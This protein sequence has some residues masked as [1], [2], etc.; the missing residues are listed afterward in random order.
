MYRGDEP[1]PASWDG[2]D[3]TRIA[4]RIAERVAELIGGGVETVV[5]ADEGVRG[6]EPLADLFARDHFAWTLEKDGEQ[7][8]GLFLQAYLD[9]A[10]TELSVP[11]VR[12]ENSE[13]DDVR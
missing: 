2:L 5:E 13:T 7:A 10:P 6:P 3:E 1:V 12:L 9:T 4:R 8:K 11:E